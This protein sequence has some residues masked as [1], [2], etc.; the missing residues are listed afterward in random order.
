[1]LLTCRRDCQQP[2]DKFAV[3]HLYPKSEQALQG[4]RSTRFRIAECYASPL[5]QPHNAIIFFDPHRKLWNQIINVEQ[6]NYSTFLIAKCKNTRMICLTWQLI[7][8]VVWA[9]YRR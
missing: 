6:S 2:L 8:K 9:P 5:I 1:M 7:F 4:L 3:P